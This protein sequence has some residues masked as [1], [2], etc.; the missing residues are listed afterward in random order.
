MYFRAAINIINYIR[1]RVVQLV[2]LI[3]YFMNKI[4]KKELFGD[5]LFN[6]I[7]PIEQAYCSRGINKTESPLAID[8]A[9]KGWG[10]PFLNFTPKIDLKA[11][12]FLKI[13]TYYTVKIIE[14]KIISEFLKFIF[15][16]LKLK[17]IIQN[18]TGMRY[19]VD[20]FTDY[21][22]EHVPHDLQNTALYA[23]QW[24]RDLAFTKNTLKI[25]ILPKL[26]TKKD[27]PLNWL[28]RRDTNQVLESGFDRDIALPTSCQKLNVNQLTG[29]AGSLCLIQPK[30]C[31]HK[32]GIP[33]FGN[34]R[35][36]I[37]IQLN[38]SRHWKIRSDLY[39]KQFTQEP[40]MPFF[41]NIFR[42][43]VNL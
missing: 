8:L 17:E 6:W 29:N 26:V 28:D 15:I 35:E 23:N 25:F 13:H 2:D 22:T 30:I 33:E 42:H 5:L 41:K 18:A 20:F 24:H 14:A 11:E 39:E 1:Q 34:S 38:P 7:D 12:N 43:S 27:G 36:Q 32:A 9:T 10:F 21:I 16:E 3:L 40:N 19:S 31:L 37:M 4:N